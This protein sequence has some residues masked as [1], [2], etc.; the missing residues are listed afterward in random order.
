MSSIYYYTLGA[1]REHIHYIETLGKSK[2]FKHD[3][4]VF[5]FVILQNDVTHISKALF[6][7]QV[8]I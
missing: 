2:T 8:L 1:M 5:I 6:K 4:I 7:E 3:P